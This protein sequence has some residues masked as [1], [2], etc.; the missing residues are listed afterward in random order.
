MFAPKYDYLGLNK[1]M[2]LFMVNSSVNFSGVQNLLEGEE[3]DSNPRNWTWAKIFSI[4]PL[5][6]KFFFLVV[7]N[8]ETLK[9]L[10]S[11]YANNHPSMHM[12]QPSCP[13]K[14]GRH[15]PYPVLLILVDCFWEKRAFW[16]CWSYISQWFYRWE[17]SRRSNAWSRMAQSSGQ[18]EGMFQRTMLE[19]V[20][21]WWSLSEKASTFLRQGC[22]WH[23]PCEFLNKLRPSINL[24]VI[25]YFKHS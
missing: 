17:H 2:L 10:A 4:S 1:T 18:H 25:F 24:T 8:K 11:L 20:S 14:S 7:E 22:D 13:N 19:W 3:E 16:A 21:E 12:G 15:F 9:H 6:F 23:L 5:T